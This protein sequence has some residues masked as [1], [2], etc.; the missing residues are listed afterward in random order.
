MSEPTVDSFISNASELQKVAEKPNY[1]FTSREIAIQYAYFITGGLLSLSLFFTMIA[2]TDNFESLFPNKNYGFY[3]VS[4]NFIS[5]PIGIV[6]SKLTQN[7]PLR[8]KLL[9][10]LLVVGFVVLVPPVTGLYLPHENLEFWMILGA[11]TLVYAIMI[12]F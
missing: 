9:S 11:Y 3:V 4:P 2:Q 12:V 7:I 8:I 6:I 5:L 10:I 1:A